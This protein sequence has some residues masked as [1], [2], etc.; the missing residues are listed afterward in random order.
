MQLSRKH[1]YARFALNDKA[2]NSSSLISLSFGEGRGEVVIF[3]LSFCSFAFF[4]YAFGS[5][6]RRF[7]DDFTQFC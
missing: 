1:P 6:S 7:R 2:V 3:F 5:P 4:R